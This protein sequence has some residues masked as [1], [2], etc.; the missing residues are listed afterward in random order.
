MQFKS[1]AGK[2]VYLNGEIREFK[3]GVY[4][5]EDKAEIEIL[6]TLKDVTKVDGRTKK[7]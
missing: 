6:Q 4:E 2:K 3:D 1:K 7:E 5:T